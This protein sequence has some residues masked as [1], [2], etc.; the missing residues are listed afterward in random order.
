MC[1]GTASM[2]HA[3]HFVR[4][5][6]EQ[7][8][9]HKGLGAPAKPAAQ[10]AAEPVPTL[11]GPAAN[12]PANSPPGPHASRA[13]L[14]PVAEFEW[15]QQCKLK[16][17]RHRSIFLHWALSRCLCTT[18]PLIVSRSV[19]SVDHNTIMINKSW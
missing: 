6:E 16:W 12:P 13:L 5:I 17:S 2:T 18:G 4:N 11:A 8:C 9:L 3:S 1:G 10:H 7:K 15:V 19:L 14:I